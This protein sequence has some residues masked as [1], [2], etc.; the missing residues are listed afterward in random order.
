MKRNILKMLAGLLML[1]IITGC[2]SVTSTKTRLVKGPDLDRT[3]P[4]KVFKIDENVSGQYEILGVVTASIETAM[5]RQ[6]Y[7]EEDRLESLQADASSM[8][9]DAIIGYY[10]NKILAATK[11]YY[12]SSGLAA[13][14][15][16]SG[17]QPLNSNSDCMVALPK[18]VINKVVD[19]EERSE[20]LDKEARKCA[21]YYL[22][23]NGYY[24]VPI[25]EPTPDPA[26]AGFQA[27][28]EDELNKY[29]GPQTLYILGAK[30]LDKSYFTVLL[31]SRESIALEMF[32]YSKTLKRLVWQGK[33]T[34]SSTTGWIEN[35]ANTISEQRIQEA[36]R[37]AVSES[38]KDVPNISI[39]GE[40]N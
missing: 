5:N 37:E 1:I 18:V 10:T 7:R 27:M 30:Y 26:L 40:K 4:I 32:L 14:M 31:G 33:G 28:N 29:G 16:R 17:E 34:G 35:I 39:N 38:L 9:A 11:A 6:S 21:Q 22:A 20:I 12:W 13:R 2:A 19:S 24:A 3:R 36:I 15:R 23:L 25:D 8:G